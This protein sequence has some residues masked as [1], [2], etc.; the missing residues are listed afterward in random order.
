MFHKHQSSFSLNL[1]ETLKTAFF[2]MRLINLTFNYENK[3][4]QCTALFHGCKNVNFQIKNY[5]IFLIFSHNIDCG[6]TLDPPH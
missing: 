2:T 4:M 3:P 5:N 6:Y 1:S